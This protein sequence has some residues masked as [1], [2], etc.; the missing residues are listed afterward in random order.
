M[1][2]V[3]FA[4]HESGD[5]LEA[6]PGVDGWLRQRHQRAVRLLIELHE[7]QVPELEE[8]S[9]FGAFDEGILREF[10]AT[11]LGPLTRGARR[12]PE[13]LRQV[14]EVDEDLAAR[15]A[16]TSVGH[17]PEI[18]VRT[19]TVNSGIGQTSDLT[20]QRASLVV[21][22]VYGHANELG[23]QLQLFGDELPGK[24]D[25]IALEI[26]AK[27][28]IAEHLEE[29]VVPR[30]VA[31]LLEIVV[32][33]AGPDTLLHRGR[34]S[35]A[36]RLLLAEKYFLELHHAGVG[37]HQRRVVARQHRRARVDD[38]PVLFEVLG[39]FASDFG[40]GHARKYTRALWRASTRVSACGR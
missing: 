4:L 1:K 10:L 27:R 34:A 18:V 9:R 3:R 17:L 38:M 21:L 33:A 15:T 35:S 31:D 29:G 32:L 23:R 7:D 14:G 22:L 25:R 20:P 6:S 16:G 13:I 30:G 24:A 36:G 19:E 8:S 5:A 28:E 37:E 2:I 39:E 26:V 40:G 12:D 11:D